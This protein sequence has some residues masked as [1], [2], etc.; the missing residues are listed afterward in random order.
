MAA[1]LIEPKEPVTALPTLVDADPTVP[2]ATP[3][4]ALVS[5]RNA[6]NIVVAVE[7]KTD[8]VNR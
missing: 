7:C 3:L 8:C 6:G 1:M 4:T 2:A 5:P